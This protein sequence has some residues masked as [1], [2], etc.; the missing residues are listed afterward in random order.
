MNV[1]SCSYKGNLGYCCRTYNRS[2][3]FV[4]DLGQY[5]SKIYRNINL[6]DLI[7]TNPCARQFELDIEMKTENN[8]LMSFL[9]KTLRKKYRPETIGGLLFYPVRI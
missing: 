1:Y 6:E 3:M 2:W 7:F 9:S 5:D 4:P 8:G